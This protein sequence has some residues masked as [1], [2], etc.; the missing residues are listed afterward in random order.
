MIPVGLSTSA[1]VLT[2]RYIGMNRVD[3]AKKISNLVM[4]FTLLWTVFLMVLIYYKM[5]PIIDFYTNDEEVK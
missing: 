5:D 1:N 4:L 3:L 2:G